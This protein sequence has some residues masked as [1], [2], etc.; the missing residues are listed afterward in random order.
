MLV[1][2]SIFLAT[3]AVTGWSHFVAQRAPVVVEEPSTLELALVGVVTLAIYSVVGR[4]R[5]VR[6]AKLPRPTTLTASDDAPSQID[7]PSREAA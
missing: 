1:A 6:E 5:R 7:P 2:L 3:F 4:W